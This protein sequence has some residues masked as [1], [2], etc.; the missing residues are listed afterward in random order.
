MKALYDM[1]SHNMPDRCRKSRA[2]CQAARSI[3]LAS[4]YVQAL[5]VEMVRRGVENI[6]QGMKEIG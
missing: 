3:T 6:A 5:G 2:S 4:N 1:A